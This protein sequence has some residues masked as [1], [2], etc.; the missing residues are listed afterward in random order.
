MSTVSLCMIVKNEEEMLPT[1]L[2]SVRQYVDEMVVVDTG[3]TDRTVEI[4]EEMGARVE[5]FE[6]CDDFAAARNY[7]VS[8]VNSDYLLVLDA[9]EVL[10]EESAKMLKEYLDSSEVYLGMVPLHQAKTKEDTPEEVV[11]GEQRNGAP[12]FLPRILKN[13]DSLKY[14]GPIH[15]SPQLG[16]PDAPVRLLPLHIVHLGADAEFRASREKSERNLEMLLKN[17]DQFEDLSQYWTYLASELVVAGRNEEAAQAIRKGWNAYVTS[18]ENGEPQVPTLIVSLYPIMLIQQGRLQEGLDALKLF[19]S[20]DIDPQFLD[21]NTLYFTSS[22]LVNL[23]LPNQIKVTMLNLLIDIA[24]FCVKSKDMIFFAEVEQG[25]INY[26]ARE[27]KAQALLLLGR[28]DESLSI[29]QDLVEEFP[30][31]NRFF[32][33]QAEILVSYGSREKSEQALSIL[34]PIL[35]KEDAHPD[36]WLIAATCCVVL[37]DYQHARSFWAIG[38]QRKSVPFYSEHR[39]RLLSGLNVMFS[40]F[41]GEPILGKG[42]YG[43]LSSLMLSAP[44]TSSTDVPKHVLRLV[45]HRLLA[46]EKVEFIDKLLTR[47]AEHVLP[48][49]VEFVKEVLGELGLEIFDDNEFTGVFVGGHQNGIFKD[50]L[51]QHSNFQCTKDLGYHLHFIKSMEEFH[52]SKKL[53]VDP[54]EDAFSWLNEDEEDVTDEGLDDFLKKGIESLV[55]I[56]GGDPDRRFVDF[57][58]DN[59]SYYKKLLKLFPSARIVHVIEDPRNYINRMQKEALDVEQD[60]SWLKQQLDDWQLE[61]VKVRQSM[62][63]FTVNYIETS[64]SMLHRGVVDEV[65]RILSF[66]DEPPSIETAEIISDKLDDFESWKQELDLETIRLIEDTLGEA[67]HQLGFFPHKE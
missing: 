49:V 17:I 28:L 46:V 26:K 37:E 31:S 32:V 51:E 58:S 52:E 33:W 10:I 62:K 36:P 45:V 21:P 24:D 27:L 38:Q 7:A 2:N 34:L 40:V 19:F 57:S 30:E 13:V 48:G 14:V 20:Q 5:Y 54:F 23:E 60:E 50:G 56:I 18:I 53:D 1:C 25:I 42:A 61:L 63:P 43:V 11:S 65:Q 67:F 55:D 35:E 59:K 22:I 4:A 12:V 3:S 47:R 15:E 41:E 44:L 64:I 16:M 9:D 29:I 8:K 66:L 39:K 6:W